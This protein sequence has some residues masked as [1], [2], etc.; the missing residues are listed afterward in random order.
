MA[1]S[2]V[3]PNSPKYTVLMYD[4][5]SPSFTPEPPSQDTGAA[6]I[7][8]ARRMF[9]TWLRDSGNDYTRADGY[10]Q[11]WADVVL[12][13]SWDGISYGDVTGGDG[14]CRLMRGPRGG[15]VRKNF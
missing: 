1:T 3:N 12:T 13:A 5:I 2:V 7:A 10:G 11:P 9:A 15:I 6:T 4:G 14:I 8:D